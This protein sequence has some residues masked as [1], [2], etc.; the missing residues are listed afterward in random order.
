MFRSKTYM[1]IPPGETIKEQLEDRNLTQKDLARLTGLSEKHISRLVNGHVILTPDTAD[2]LE[3]AIGVSARFWL[4]LEAGYRADLLKVKTENASNADS[5]LTMQEWIVQELTPQ[6]LT[7]P[8][9]AQRV[10]QACQCR[11][12]HKGRIH[13]AEA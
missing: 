9:Y 10:L 7:D 11:R 4:A 6:L 5:G 12:D 1:A 8:K 2:K 13:H 3:K